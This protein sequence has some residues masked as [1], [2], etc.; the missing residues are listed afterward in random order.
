[1][2]LNIDNFSDINDIDYDKIISTDGDIV[3]QMDNLIFNP[4]I[5]NKELH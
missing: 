2:S 4:L 5:I 1:M 3:K